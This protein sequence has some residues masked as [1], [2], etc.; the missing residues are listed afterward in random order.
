MA[1][2]LRRPERLYGAY[3]FDLDGTLYLGEDALPGAVETVAFLREAGAR[4]A[5]VTNNPLQ[6][7]AGWARKLR[8]LG[9]EVADEEVISSMD[10]LIAYLRRH[11][12][13]ARLFPIAE[14]PLIHQLVTA[15]F[16]VTADPDRTDVVVVSFDRG[17]HYDKLR[18]A[19]LAV[20]EGARIVATN[21]DA[22]CPTPD[23]GLPDCG[24]ILA[25]IEAASGKRANA[26][27]GKPSALMAATVLERL[28]SSPGDTLVVGDRLETD[29]RMARSAGLASALVLTG[30]ARVAPSPLELDRPD[31]VIGSVR[32]LTV[33]KLGLSR[34]DGR[35]DHPGQSAPGRAHPSKR[36]P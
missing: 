9:F 18:L 14:P 31:F 15:G 33:R 36:T 10:A 11:H 29:I 5:F 4:L 28:G 16:R 17:F 21:P 34:C 12:A 2:R 3:V 1:P 6:L 22:Y 25:A 20:N 30:A 7:P 8:G 13:G 23:G 26:I 19:F 32:E 27:V 35:E 24:A